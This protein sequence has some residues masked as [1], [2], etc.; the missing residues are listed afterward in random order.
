MKV[1]LSRDETGYFLSR[2]RPKTYSYWG[3]ETN[4]YDCLSVPR[5]MGKKHNLKPNTSRRMTLEQFLDPEA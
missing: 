1:W 5:E 3:I 4:E 2:T